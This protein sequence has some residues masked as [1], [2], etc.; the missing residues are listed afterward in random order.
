MRRPGPLLAA[1]ALTMSLLAAPASAYAASASRSPLTTGSLGVPDRTGPPASVPAT[2]GLAELERR[3]VEALA[4]LERARALTAAGTLVGTVRAA[5]DL[6]GGSLEV[7]ELRAAAVPA[8]VPVEIEVPVG[9]LLAA[10]EA[11]SVL[12][13]DAIRGNPQTVARLW[14]RLEGLTPHAADPATVGGI[15]RL[16]A[17][18]ERAVDA[19]AS[20]VGAL[21]LADALD[22]AIPALL[23]YGGST[24]RGAD[25]P[26]DV[27][28][29]LPALCIGGQGSSTYTEDAA[30]LIDLG[31]ED[32]H[33]NSAGGADLAVVNADG[34]ELPVS[35]TLDLGGN[36]R[37]E[38]TTPTP[39]GSYVAQGGGLE[40]G[41]GI[42]VDV[43]GNDAYTVTDG[44]TSDLSRGHGLGII[45]GTGMLADLGGNDTYRLTNTMPGGTVIGQGYGAFAAA[46]IF[47]DAAG[48][49]S[50][51]LLS[52][53]SGPVPGFFEGFASRASVQGYGMAGLGVG[54]FSDGGGADDLALEAIAAPLP[55]DDPLGTGETSIFGFGAAIIGGAGVALFGPGPTKRVARATA[56]APTITSGDI[57]AFGSGTS[58][59]YAAIADEGG[60][61]TY[62][63]E[64]DVHAVQ[65]AEITDGCECYGVEAAAE[66]T[67]V[68]IRAQGH[69]ALLG[70][71]GVLHDGAGDDL[72][73]SRITTAAEAEARDDRTELP[74]PPPEPPPGEEPVV[75]ATAWAYSWGAY[76]A[77]QGHGSTDGAGFLEDLGGDDVY[78]SVTDVSATAQASAA[79]PGSPA[80]ASSETL[81]AWSE[82]QAAGGDSGAGVLRDM[83]GSDAYGSV[84]TTSATAAPPTEEIP[85]LA[86]PYVQGSVDVGAALLMDVDGEDPANDTFV[87]VPPAPACMGTRGGQYWTDC[88]TGA[89]VGVNS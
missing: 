45:G 34:N 46:G 35:V 16:R 87:S 47:L 43:A 66:A 73:A 36:D 86:L 54:L 30:L 15:E 37:Y 57:Q 80:K 33:A 69:G 84:N 5:A 72:Y 74:P 4:P 1:L 11:A 2:L 23:A 60:N 49:D 26:C 53:P 85:G 88:G 8:S 40:G 41:I 22:S 44:G 31:G 32:V 68:S 6:A 52:A 56:E 76:S 48:D 10:V 19:D 64:L 78:E 83:G 61:D 29:A 67:G 21:V 27:V 58:A 42:L 17:G 24:S 65:R 77:V 38:T 3:R 28:D 20:L 82:A 79:D 39:S 70:G 14:Q 55:A 25:V 18:T 89:G 51:R 7:P 59:G 81:E 9:R 63:A 71:V 75:G 12:A 62:V 13:R 50:Y